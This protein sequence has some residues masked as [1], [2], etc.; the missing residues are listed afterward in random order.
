MMIDLAAQ[1]CPTRRRLEDQIAS[2]VTNLCS[3][4]S[5]L[6][7]LVGRGHQAFIS[8]EADC[9]GMRADIIDS[10]QELQDHRSAHGC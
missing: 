10:R 7:P 2:L 3:L 4:T 1:Y 8:A 6:L 5:R 9:A